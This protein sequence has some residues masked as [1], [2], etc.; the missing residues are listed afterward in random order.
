MKMYCKTR[1]EARKLA[2]SNSQV[3]DCKD[4]PSVNGLRWAVELK[5]S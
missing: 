5:R 1:A 4:K 2:N 3:V